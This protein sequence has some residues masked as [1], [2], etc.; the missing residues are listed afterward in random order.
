[1]SALNII[2]WQRSNMNR[3]E[4]SRATFVAQALTAIFIAVSPGLVSMAMAVPFYG[5][6]RF[7]TKDYPLAKFL[8]QVNSEPESKTYLQHLRDV[9][10][11]NIKCIMESSKAYYQEMDF[12]GCCDLFDNLPSIES[13]SADLLEDVNESGKQDFVEKCS[14]ISRISL[15]HSSVTST[16]LA[17]LI[18]SC[19][20]LKEFQY[21]IGGRS[22]DEGGY[23]IFSFKLL[24]K[25]LCGYK[26]TLEILDID[27][28]TGMFLLDEEEAGNRI[29][30]DETPF[31]PDIPEERL[32]FLKAIWRHGGSLKE[33]GALKRLSL[34]IKYLLY[35]AKGVSGESDDKRDMV[36]LAECLPDS[37]EYLCV[38]GYERGVNSEHD[39]QMDALMALYRSGSSNLKEVRG[40]EKLIP[41]SDD[42]EPKD[43]DRL[44]SLEERGYKDFYLSM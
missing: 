13:V 31:E 32:M 10:L 19:K 29:Q 27:C 37:L 28:K 22:S 9:Y 4:E 16:Y 23:A 38:R 7:P 5:G 36:S 39:E 34:G 33:F 44:W 6:S 35:L 12:Y 30:E 8:R 11:I 25:V 3:D 21:S 14:N 2:P 24:L 26:D 1:M 15:H 40:I 17:R 41:H 42:V 20:S 43:K 18:W